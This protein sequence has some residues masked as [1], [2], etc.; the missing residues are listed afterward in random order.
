[1]SLQTAA[2]P[3]TCGKTSTTSCPS[4]RSH[5]S[6]CS[7]TRWNLASSSGS[8]APAIMRPC[9]ASTT[10]RRCASPT[11]AIGSSSDTH[12]ALCNARTPAARNETSRMQI[13]MLSLGQR[14]PRLSMTPSHQPTRVLT[15]TD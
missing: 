4:A 9:S 11:R 14:P 13:D 1:M 10:M 8:T 6:M 3:S 15:M 5:V 2:Q 7:S 12:E